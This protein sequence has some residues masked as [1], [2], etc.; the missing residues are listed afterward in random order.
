MEEIQ[1][2]QQGLSALTTQGSGDSWRIVKNKSI[3]QALDQIDERLRKNQEQI[4]QLEALVGAKNS[5]NQAMTAVVERLKHQNEGFDEQLQSLRRKLGTLSKKVK[6]LEGQVVKLETVVVEK[7]E[8]IGKKDQEIG[9]KETALTEQ[10]LRLEAAEAEKWARYY[11]VG[12]RKELCVLSIVSPCGF[13]K[14]MVA[15]R[16]ADRHVDAFEK[17][18]E[19]CQ[20]GD[21]RSLHEIFVG[22]TRGKIEILPPR[23]AGSYAVEKRSGG[24]YLLIRDA[25]EFWKARYLVVVVER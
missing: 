10:G 14:S 13:I 17:C 20:M 5:Q 23:P 19:R 7:D 21:A 11:I 1:Q 24:L 16:L 22:K 2:G 3:P 4:G 12:T 6:S 9:I 18:G 25:G 8:V 15:P